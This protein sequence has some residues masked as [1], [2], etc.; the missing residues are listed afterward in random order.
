MLKLDIEIEGKTT[1]DLLIAL[2]EVRKKVE[3]TYTSGMD[4]NETGNYSF[5]IL[6]A[7]E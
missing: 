3:Q 5:S 6:G 7:E 4:S 2:E 1:G